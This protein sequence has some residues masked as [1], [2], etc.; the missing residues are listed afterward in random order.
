LN[1]P[2]ITWSILA[3]PEPDDDMVP[4]PTATNHSPTELLLDPYPAHVQIPASR[5]KQLDER[6]TMLVCR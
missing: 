1:F 6:S 2:L 4:N 3:N 5:L